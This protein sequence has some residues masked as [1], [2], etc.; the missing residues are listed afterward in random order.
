VDVALFHAINGL[1]GHFD[2]ADDLFETISRFAPFALI[3]LL[4]GLWFWPGNRAERAERQWAAIAATGAATLALGINQVIIHLWARPRPFVGHHAVLLLKPSTDPSFPSDHAAF[5]FGVAVA[6][7]LV[8]RRVG[9]VAVVIAALLAFSRVYVGEHY[10]GDVLA[11]A[12]VGA[13]AAL[14]V[15]AARPLVMP[16][17]EPP[18]RIA[19]RFRLA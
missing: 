15:D 10:V 7:A 5:G 6:V 18:L 4:L 9:I 11:G 8:L 3:A 14:A 13:L 1:A 16:L 19:R 2:A 17:L 12:L